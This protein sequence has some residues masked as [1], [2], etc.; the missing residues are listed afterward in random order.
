MFNF[1]SSLLL[2]LQNANIFLIIFTI[3]I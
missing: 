1:I 2:L 3:N